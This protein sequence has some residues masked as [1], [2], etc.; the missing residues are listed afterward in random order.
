ML[1][2]INAAKDMYQ[3]G[4]NEF[5]EYQKNYNDFYSPISRDMDWYNK[6]VI[7]ST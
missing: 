6:N 3:Q 4:V 1:A 5:K 2:S 7:G